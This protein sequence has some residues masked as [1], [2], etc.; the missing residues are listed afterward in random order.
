MVR[1]M[2][3]VLIATALSL[4]SSDSQAGTAEEKRAKGDKILRE[5]SAALAGMQTFGFTA[6]TDNAGAGGANTRHVVQHVVVRRPNGFR[7]LVEGNQGMNAWYDGKELTLVSDSKKVWARGEVPP[8]LDK[9]MDYVAAVYDLKL[10][11]YGGGVQYQVVAAPR[12]PSSPRFRRAA[13]SRQSATSR[14]S[15]AAR[16]ITKGSSRDTRS[17]YCSD[18]EA[19]PRPQ[20]P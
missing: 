2:I 11:V 19:A 4:A 17:L 10:L 14:T 13:R 3:V 5:M 18:G 9:A 7:S 6:V 12:E 8:T 1:R 16:R 20:L 15:S